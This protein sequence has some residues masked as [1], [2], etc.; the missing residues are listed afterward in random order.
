MNIVKNYQFKLQGEGIE[1]LKKLFIKDYKNVENPQVRNRYGIVAGIFGIVTNLIL[2][3]IKLVIGLLANSITIMADAFNN[4]SDLGSCIVTILGFKLANKPADKEHPY[5]HARYEYITGIIVSLLMLVMGGIFLKTSIGKIISPEEIK[6]SVAT[7][8][9]LIVAVLGKVLQMVVYSDF[10]KSINSSTIKATAIDARNDIIS[11]LAVLVATIIIGLFKINIDAYTGI[12]VSIFIIISSIKSLK[13]TINPLLGIIP[14]EEKINKIKEKILSHKEII[15]IHDL[16]I[17]S[18]GEQNDF[19]TVHAEVPDTM[20]IT[21]AHEVADIVEREFKEELNIDL[22]VHIDP[23]N[24]N[25]EET[26]NIKNKVEEILKK[27]DQDISIHDFRVVTAQKHTN[28]IFDIVIPYEKNYNRY[29]L[30]GVLEE[31]F[32]DEDKK[33]Y[34]VF[35]IDRPFC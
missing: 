18:Y 21:E 8:L 31:G 17:H 27:F 14:S 23:L 25:D 1:M 35:N 30:L 26:K 11:T 4:L 13:D 20:G 24:I 22:T 7:Y 33:Y 15:G 6:I 5:G 34:F 32:K 9:V 2:F 12:I 28:A 16:R 3:L 19:V 10:A 29:E